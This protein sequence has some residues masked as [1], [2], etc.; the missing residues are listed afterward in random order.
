[1]SAPIIDIADAVVTALNAADLSQ[2]F[3][4]V[5]RY[6][7]KF[8]SS[9]DYS[10]QV[11]VVPKSEASEIETRGS[12]AADLSIDIGVFKKLES[13]GSKAADEIAEID[14]LMAL[15]EEIKVV[16]NR[17]RLADVEYAICN[18]ISRDLIYSVDDVEGKR[19][20]LT[21]ITAVFRASLAV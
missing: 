17:Q 20:F 8:D 3:T 5:R 19:V 7:P 12:D 10:V 11:Q 2:S 18:R 6:V 16:V 4:A 21:V 15:C 14:A 9:G 13:D 1:M